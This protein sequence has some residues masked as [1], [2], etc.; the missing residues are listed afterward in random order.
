MPGLIKLMIGKK[1]S[2]KSA[3]FCIL[4]QLEPANHGGLLNRMPRN[5]S[6]RGKREGYREV[7]LISS[8]LLQMFGKV[9]CHVKHRHLAFATKNR[10]QL[11]ICIDHPSI[12]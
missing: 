11:R 9:L 1:G 8:F 3:N 10:F 4:R 7:P 2:S 5:A 6:H 12:L